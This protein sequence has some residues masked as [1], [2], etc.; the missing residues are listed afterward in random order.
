M[1]L[2]GV[3][4]IERTNFMGSKFKSFVAFAAKDCLRAEVIANACKRSNN[5]N[6]DFVPWNSLDASGKAIDKAVHDWV[7]RSDALIADISEANHNVTFEIGMA[8]GSGMPLRLIRSNNADWKKIEEIGL[9]H[10]VGHDTYQDTDS[11]IQILGSTSDQNPWPHSRKNQIQPVYL[12]ESANL[13]DS[14]SHLVSGLKKTV[15]LRYRNFSPREIDRLTASE[16]F[17]QI[18]Q[19]FGITAIWHDDQTDA[20]FKQNQRIAFSMG[21]ARGLGTPF[22]LLASNDQRLPLDLDEIATRWTKPQHIRS[23]LKKFRDEVLEAQ[24]SWVEAPMVGK[25]YLNRINCGDPA[26]ENEMVQLGNYF[27]ET[28][29]FR[30]T[31]N[32]ELNIITG[33]KGSGKSAI[34]LQ[35]RNRVRQN[36][37]NVVVDLAPQGFQL[38]RLKE[39]VL[40]TLGHGARKEFITAFW[41][42][43][44]WLEIAYKLIEKDRKKAQF[45]HTLADAYTSL[46]DAYRQRVDSVGDFSERLSS[47]TDRIVAR[48]ASESYNEDSPDILSSKILEVVYGSELTEIRDEVLSYLK[49]KGIVFFLF[50]NLDR[51]WT[52]TGFAEVDAHIIIGLVEC[53][54]DIRKRFDRAAIEFSWAIFL[55]SDVYEFVVK[56][57]A[58]YGKLATSSIEWNDKELLLRMFQNR[59][60]RSLNAKNEEWGDIWNAVSVPKVGTKRTEDFL[61]DASLGRPRYLIRLFETARRRAITLRKDQISE[62]DYFQAVEELGWQ[63]LEDFDRE[64]S[65]V[66]PSAED[67]LFSLA[68]LGGETSISAIHHAIAASSVSQDKVE[69]VVDVLIWTGCLG[70]E[71]DTGPRYISDCGFRRPFMKGL[72]QK[73][74]NH[75]VFHPT[76]AAIF[77][78]SFRPADQLGS[79]T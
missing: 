35:A 24:A 26:A 27:L 50:D 23:R 13:D 11:L 44:V 15:L 69:T 46:E 4:V 7:S 1:L 55:R 10:N 41:E 47:L 78:G 17:E 60:L 6:L 53:L 31:L 19:S 61:I 68:Q 42:Y 29:Q 36:K 30:Q 79:L 32:G 77:T 75:I 63:V 21:L 18:T 3:Q 9:L 64:L 43:I 72:M 12:L 57:M 25:S 38:V 67:L 37:S 51:F 52:P 54:T 56:G 16:A 58:D 22:L 28:E 8:I 14:M 34:F 74:K 59:F 71:T 39:F 33:R 65:D 5:K 45:D 62:D 66:I 49:T 76:L 70:V 48:Y 73:H 20:G 40:E 2:P